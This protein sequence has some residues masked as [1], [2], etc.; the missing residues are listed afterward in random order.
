MILG[1]LEGEEPTFGLMSYG[2]GVPA[3]GATPQASSLD[4]QIS[5]LEQ[6]RTDLL[7]EF[8][9]KHPEVV[10]ID[11]LLAELRERRSEELATRPSIDESMP[12]I[13]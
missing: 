8:T 10:R 2:F 9:E 3:G 11:S 13:T 4:A 6:R 12:T 5:S 1:Q 7:I